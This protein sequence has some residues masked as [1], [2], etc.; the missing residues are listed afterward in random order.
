MK[1]IKFFFAVCTV[2]FFFTGCD[3]KLDPF[4]SGSNS[5]GQWPDFGKW[6]NMSGPQAH[7]RD[8]I[9]APAALHEAASKENTK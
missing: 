5:S 9:P 6:P 8:T 1:T 7:K 4:G 2:A 3:F